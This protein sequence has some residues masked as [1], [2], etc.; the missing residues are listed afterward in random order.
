M[1]TI[2][3]KFQQLPLTNIENEEIRY[4]LENKKISAILVDILDGDLWGSRVSVIGN[5]LIIIAILFSSADFIFN[6]SQFSRSNLIINFKWLVG[7]FFLL[8]VALRISYAG[9]LGYGIGFAA[10]LKYIFSFMGLVD[11]LS[12]I[13]VVLE[14][15]GIPVSGGISAI[16]ILRI[17]RIARFIKAFNSIS[18]AFHSR[19]QEILVTLFGV[20]LLSLTLSAVMFHFES[21]NGSGSFKSIP[22][23]FIWSIGKYTGDYGAIAGEVP[24]TQVG[25]SIATI[26]GL[27]GIALF[28]IPA[29]L[30]ASAFIDQLAENRKQKLINERTTKIIQFFTRSKGGGKQ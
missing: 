15:L 21:E 12:L 19:R 29:G 28:A 14:L 9:F 7:L 24:L 3:S 11:I 1:K 8:E 4:R 13:P 10:R 25:K 18:K 16:R 6:F 20:L 2:L 5:F 17:W 27:L 30:L 23:V 22:Q 26:N